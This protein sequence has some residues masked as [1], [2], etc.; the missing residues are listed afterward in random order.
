MEATI[1]RTQ[2]REE[3]RPANGRPPVVN[4]FSLVVATANG[5]GSQTSNLTLLRALFKMGIPVNG[6]NI[7]PSN[8]QGLPTWYHI[9][10]SHEGFVARRHTSEILVAFN[11]DTVAEDIANL[12]AGGVC[13][14]NADWRDVPLR[15]D[16]VNYAIPVNLF[17]RE[18]GVK[19]KIRDYL[20]NM[21][22]VGAVAQLLAIDP[23]KVQ[24][25]LSFHFG[26]RQSLVEQNM[27]VVRL[28]YDWT[29]A[30]I[31]KRDPYTVRP[32]NLTQGK[33][34]ITGNEAA[35]LGAIFGGATVVAWYPITPSTSLVDAFSGFLPRLRRDPETGQETCVVIQAED[36]LAAAGM[37]IGAGWAGARAMTA[38]SGPGISLMA[39]FVGLGYFA[40]IPAVIWDIQRVGPS[41][42]LPTRTSQ[43]DLLFAYF[44]GHGDTKNV[45]LLPA[46][47]AEC[48]AF[49]TTAFNLAEELQT[50]VFVMSDLDLGMNNWLTDPFEY[51]K[52]PIKR[53]K[54][55]AAEEVAAKGFARYVDL[56]GD[57]ITYRTLPGNEHPKAVYFARGTGH[58]EVAAYSEKPEDWEAN[59]LR[60][61]RKFE[62][63]RQMVPR[64]VIEETAGARAGLIAYG[65]TLPAVEEARHRLAAQGLPTGFLRLRAL[66]INDEVRDFVACYDRVY[67]V[68]LNRDGQMHQV[69]TVELP[70]LAT[71]MISLAHLDGMPLTARWLV[72]AILDKEQTR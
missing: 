65:S 40:E 64:P 22:Y 63:A 17:L 66:P 50:P 10:V 28:A 56:D 25:A 8:I 34:L 54:V 15:Q 45:L 49:G 57:G 12:P 42:G 53:G 16:V 44:L 47:V 55:L 37:V 43:G 31:D 4:D 19:G 58:N 14:Y 13:L 27:Q 18:A 21:V 51:P 52:E 70:D 1:S 46:T 62:T 5:T 39:E 41:T 67:V 68:E 33:I 26:G 20:A 60:L 38:T 59:M 2:P 6:K 71:K 69:L 29:A 3:T 24:E 30:N 32:M 23:D 61:A 9:R 36:E 35:A 11:Q 72:E 48:F 7:F